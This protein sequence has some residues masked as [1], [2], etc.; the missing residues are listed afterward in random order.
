MCRT[1]QL[2]CPVFFLVDT[3]R[4]HREH[5]CPLVEHVLKHVRIKILLVELLNFKTLKHQ[6][7]RYPNSILQILNLLVVVL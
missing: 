2:T 4:T 1:R 5:T 7:I 6:I 3:S